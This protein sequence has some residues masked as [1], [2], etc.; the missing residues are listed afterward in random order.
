MRKYR[1]RTLRAIH[2]AYTPGESAVMD[3]LY[4]FLD[5]NEPELVYLLQN[6]WNAQGRAITYKELREAILS[7]EIDSKMIDEWMQDYSRFVQQHLAPIWSRAMVAANEL[8]SSDRPPFVFDPMQA[9]VINWTN[10][11]AAAFVTS[12]TTEQIKG[13]REVIKMASQTET[14][15]SVDQLSR[16][17]RPMV[18]LNWQ[19]SRANMRYYE[20]MV[21]S[22]MSHQKALDKAIRYSARQSMYRGYM[23]ARTELVFAYNQGS[24]FGIEQAQEQ[25]LMGDVVKIWCASDDERECDICN[26]LERQSRE[27]YENGTGYGLRDDFDFKTK[28]TD[29]GI[30][31]VPPAHP[32]CRCSI[33]L[34]EITPPIISPENSN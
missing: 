17:I 15:M 24:L 6:T 12:V 10:D 2:K 26:E 3:K 25:G 33:I 31:R 18:G 8:L 7:G 13:L 1:K 11:R 9:G 28:L 32:N 34:E 23:I 5:T 30:K 27:A 21:N 16:A 22:G 20:H 14:G 19:Q 4:S 29:I